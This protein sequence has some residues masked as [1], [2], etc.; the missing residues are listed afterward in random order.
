MRP[1]VVRGAA[2]PSVPDYPTPLCDDD[3]GQLV[4]HS[5]C[6]ILEHDPASPAQQKSHLGSSL[7]LAYCSSRD[8]VAR[9]Q[10]QK[11]A[12]LRCTVLTRR[13]SLL[14]FRLVTHYFIAKCTCVGASHP[15]KRKSI[16]VKLQE[17][18]PKVGCGDVSN[19]YKYPVESLD[20]R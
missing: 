2:M 9:L 13:T 15:S 17:C 14:A 11:S 7:L 18:R 6:K 4:G 1:W 3:D 8:V 16:F 5:P 12:S 19:W 20:S 10:P